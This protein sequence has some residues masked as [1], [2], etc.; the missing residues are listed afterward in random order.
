[1]RIEHSMNHIESRFESFQ[2]LEAYMTKH[3][4]KLEKLAAREGNAKW[5]FGQTWQ[6][7][8][9]DE[10]LSEFISRHREASVPEWLMAFIDKER[11]EAERRLAG[12]SSGIANRKR[13]RRWAEDG[14]EADFD[15]WQAGEEKCY[16][17]KARGGTPPTAE[18]YVELSTDWT[19]DEDVF[20]S[21]L[22]AAAATCGTLR[23][24]G[25]R[26]KIF[27]IATSR[28]LMAEDTS[29]TLR[30]MVLKL[31]DVNE[32]T[33]EAR[34]AT[35]ASPAGFRHLTFHWMDAHAK[36]EGKTMSRNR[37]YATDVRQ[38]DHPLHNNKKAI[39]VSGSSAPEIWD[40]IT[41][42]LKRSGLLK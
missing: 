37:G 31:K 34:I 20:F 18:V 1:M 10:A 3:G 42:S 19:K 25:I 7:K 29:K 2:E 36:E 11:P 35:W 28:N 21:R 8:Y 26:T 6:T 27:V 15:K 39:L 23:R 33:D 12:L 14:A 16:L 5:I 4:C 30:S 32:T 17:S 13:R 22:A 38:H 40:T 9:S 24:K 41:N